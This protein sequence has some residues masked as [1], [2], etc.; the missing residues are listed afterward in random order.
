MSILYL[1]EAWYFS[2]FTKILL[3]AFLI[4]D[5]S[6]YTN[7]DSRAC[8]TM[9]EGN[10]QDYLCCRYF[11]VLWQLIYE[12]K[13]AGRGEGFLFFCELLYNVKNHEGVMY[14]VPD[15]YILMSK[16]FCTRKSDHWIGSVRIP[17]HS[18]FDQW[19]RCA[20]CRRLEL[21]PGTRTDYAPT[22]G[23]RFLLFVDKIL[24][25]AKNN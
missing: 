8:L 1:T 2:R 3:M 22:Q 15:F 10:G 12:P 4:F 23:K 25:L 17:P 6:N 16:R 14:F 21:F 11:P 7:R 19:Q 18:W 9:D 20:G 24:L 13:S 5:M